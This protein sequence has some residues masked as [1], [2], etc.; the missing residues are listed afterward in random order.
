MINNAHT[1]YFGRFSCS[2][3][4]SIVFCLGTYMVKIHEHK[5]FF[6]RTFRVNIRN[7]KGMKCDM[8]NSQSYLRS[9]IMQGQ[10]GFHVSSL[11]TKTSVGKIPVSTLEVCI[12]VWN[13]FGKR[14]KRTCVIRITHSM[15][16]KRTRT[17]Q[18]NKGC[19]RNL[20]FCFNEDESWTWQ[21]FFF[22]CF[23]FWFF[24]LFFF[25]RFEMT[26]WKSG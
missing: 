20:K 5:I 14:M 8:A 18:E 10:I 3:D 22:C 11:L 26:R 15:I 25:D 17:K 24:F 2:R 7:R 6:L 16:H 23:C 21:K 13:K 9:I 4:M 1:V 12:F 19:L